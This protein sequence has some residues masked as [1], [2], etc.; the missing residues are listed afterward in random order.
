[1][2]KGEYARERPYIGEV[3]GT[4]AYHDKRDRARGPECRLRDGFFRQKTKELF[5][6]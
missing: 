5:T 2:L 6:N 3:G 1:M 4:Y